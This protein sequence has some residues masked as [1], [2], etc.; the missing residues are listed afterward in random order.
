VAL[1]RDALA[2]EAGL[3]ADIGDGWTLGASYV[4][5]FGG[6]VESNGVKANLAWHF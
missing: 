1:A 5:R 4:G 2:I 6:G 3:D